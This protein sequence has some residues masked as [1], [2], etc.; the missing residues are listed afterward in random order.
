VFTTC[1]P[2]NE[3]AVKSGFFSWL[4]AKE[5]TQTVHLL[6][7]KKAKLSKTVKFL[8]HVSFS[9]Q[10][11]GSTVPEPLCRGLIFEGVVGKMDS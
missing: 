2:T 3:I 6:S 9:V 10:T 8:N 1:T 11:H 5:L 7:R 4:Q